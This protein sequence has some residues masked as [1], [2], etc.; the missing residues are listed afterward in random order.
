MTT[1]PGASDNK[2]KISNHCCLIAAILVAVLIAVVIAIVRSKVRKQPSEGNNLH[3]NS[4][5]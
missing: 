5:I 3:I 1:P 4:Y 2:N